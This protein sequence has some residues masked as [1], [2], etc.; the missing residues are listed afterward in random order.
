MAVIPTVWGS[1][2]RRIMVYAG[3]GIKRDPVSKITN[4]ERAIDL[5]EVVEA[6]LANARP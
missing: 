2:A 6:C 3:P 4:T 5:A 1:S